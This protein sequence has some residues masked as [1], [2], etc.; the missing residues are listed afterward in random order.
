M[1]KIPILTILFLLLSY[2]HAQSSQAI[3]SI[4][5]K[6]FVTLEEVCYLSAVQQ[7][8]VAEDASFSAA[9]EFLTRINQIPANQQPDMPVPFANLSYI[10]AQTWNIEGGLMYR[11]FRSAPRYA[12]KQLKHDG[13]LSENADPSKY[14]TGI[15][16]VEIFKKCQK[17]YGKSN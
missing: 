11:I 3:N 17:K 14:V 5:K 1:K 13:I 15:Q 8:L 12:Y 2:A 9:F 7:G 4:S 6:E 10:Y 16:S